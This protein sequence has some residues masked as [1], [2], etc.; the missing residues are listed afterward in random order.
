MTFLIS[1]EPLSE[2]RIGVTGTDEIYQNVR[3]IL[4]TTQGSVFLDRHF[5]TDGTLIDQPSPAAMARY[6][7][8]VVTEIEKQEPRGKVVSVSF[9]TADSDSGD[10]MLR[11]SV[12]IKIKPGVLL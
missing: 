12:R 6:R 5:G 8:H 2:I 3:T 9:G 1:G 11:P 7:N 10:G 4:A